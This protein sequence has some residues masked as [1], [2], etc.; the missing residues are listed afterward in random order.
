MANSKNSK[1]KQNKKPTPKKPVTH[2]KKALAEFEEQQRLMDLEVQANKNRIISIVIFA[3]SVLFFFVAVIPGENFWND[4]HNVYIGLFGWMASIV[5][6]LLSLIYSFLVQKTKSSKK[7][8][9]EPICIVLIVLFISTFIYIVRAKSGVPFLDTCKSEFADAPYVFN[10]GFFGAVL[11]WLFMT[12]GKAPAVVVDLLLIIVVI[13]LLSKVTV[14]QFFKNTTK[15]VRAVVEKATPY[16]EERRERRR[17]N[18]IDIPLDDEPPV[19]D[20]KSKKKAKTKAQKAQDVEET[21]EPADDYSK[22]IAEINETTSKNKQNRETPKKKSIDDIV[23]TASEENAE[24][25]NEEKTEP[26]P[27]FVV[28]E[29]D[30]QKEVK[31][32]KLPSVDILKTVKHKSAKDVSDE[33]KN[34]AELLVETLASFGVQAEITDISRGPTVTRYE[35]K[36]ASG[37]RISKITNLSDDIALNLA[38]VNVRIEAPIPGKAAVGIEI[39]NTV[40]NSVSMREVIDSADFNR[41]KS[42]LSAGLGKDIAGKTVFCD[43]AKMP[44]LLIAG[45]TGS[46]KSV[47]MNSIIVSILYR[48]NPEE[49]KFLMIDP[50]KVEF[51][52][53][54]NIPHLLVPVVTDPRKAS[55]ALGWAVSEMLERYQKFSDTGVRDIEGYNRYVEKHEDMKPMPKIVICIDELADLMMAAPKEVEDSICR[56]AQMAR[57]AGMHLVIA[58]QR[59]S[60][61]VITGLIKANIS[62]RI[63]LTVSSAIDSRT[64]LDSSGAEKLLGMGDMLYSPIGSNKPLRVQGCYISDE[65]VEKLCEFIKNQGESEYSEKIQ[66]EIESKAAQDK[67]STKFTDGGESGENLDPLFDDAVDVVLENGKASTSF[68]QRKLGVGYSRGS[69]IMDQMEDKHIIGPAEGAKPRKILINKQQW[70]QIKAQGPAPEFTAENTEQMAFDSEEVIDN[71]DLSEDSYE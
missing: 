69:K 12:L 53:Y 71:Q 28:T 62:S 38:A 4:V 18:N 7:M 66:K 44:H 56:L 65:E 40:K 50:K 29:E 25:P 64:I 27:E 6:P 20:E 70:I 23:K 41:Q 48:A 49:V 14:N 15:P 63:A 67:T 60:V 2:S 47:C 30:M 1:Q 34:N 43:I 19:Q 57:A 9:A 17:M 31:E 22:L 42:L 39:P 51:S 35:L 52:K 55:G 32:Y 46:G 16:I 61:D 24:K 5:F 59:P 58:T 37:V 10:G 3:F 54:E 8:I 13:M 36:P 68:L 45:T 11:G 33:L 21:E 26:V